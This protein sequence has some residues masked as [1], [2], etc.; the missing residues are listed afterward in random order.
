MAT[1]TEEKEKAIS[2]DERF[3]LDYVARGGKA[4]VVASGQEIDKENV[5]EFLRK[6]VAEDKTDE[7]K[8]SML[9]KKTRLQQRAEQKG[10]ADEE[11]LARQQ[12]QEEQNRAAEMER[13]R[14]QEEDKRLSQAQKLRRASGEAAEKFGN[15]VQPALDK[16]AGLH[17]VGGIGLLLVIL[18][19]LIF[20]VVQVNAQGDTRLKLLWAMLNG[21]AHLQGRVQATGTG[22]NPIAG[23]GTA[24]GGKGNN[25]ISGVG[26][27][28]QP[29]SSNGFR[30][31]TTSD[32]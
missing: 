22:G 7:Q 14:K 6:A 30:A 28:V 10:A 21:N 4:Q 18:T 5:D 3:L 11:R 1:A 17:T 29:T 24:V 12:Q 31:F 15:S 19:I 13:K 20:T 23:V 27:A 25:P 8:A 9:Q 16:V 32:F 2:V 26:A